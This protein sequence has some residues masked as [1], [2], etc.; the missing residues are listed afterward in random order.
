M[1]RGHDHGG[2]EGEHHEHGENE[3]LL[4]RYPPKQVLTR[5]QINKCLM[6]IEDTHPLKDMV[7]VEHI[8]PVLKD[9]PCYRLIKMNIGFRQA[10]RQSVCAELG[11]NIPESEKSLL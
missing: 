6:D 2:M 4:A 7:G 9:L 1:G 5:K 11:I 8:T 3:S 10:V